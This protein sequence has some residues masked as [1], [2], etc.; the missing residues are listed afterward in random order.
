MPLVLGHVRLD[1]GQFPHLV[2]QRLRVAARELRAAA[3]TLGRLQRLHV[4]AL[5]GGN[6]RPLVFLVAGLAATLLLRL[7]FRRLRPSVWMLRA[8]RQR[9]VLRRLAFHL[10][11]EFLDLRLQLG[12]LR[13]QQADDGLGFRRLA[14]DAFFR[15]SKRH[16]SCC[17]PTPPS[18]SRS[19]YQETASSP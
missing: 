14:S 3:P 8:R 13:Q 15:D 7:V 18:V 1:L 5:V 16:A 19:V 2:P 6:Q 4:V 9:G 12:N 11:L 17:R 10:P